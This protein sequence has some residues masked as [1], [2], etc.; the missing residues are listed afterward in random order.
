MKKDLWNKNEI[1]FPRLLAELAA[2]D[3]FTPEV[4]AQL[5][6][7]TDLTAEQI[8]E[9]LDRAQVEWEKVKLVNCPISS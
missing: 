3:A 6:E 5:C 9:L 7:L 2:T 8:D 4:V 1:Q